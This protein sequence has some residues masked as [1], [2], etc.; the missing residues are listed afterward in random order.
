MREKAIGGGIDLWVQRLVAN[1]LTSYRVVLTKLAKY[2]ELGWEH[3][4][5]KQIL[6]NNA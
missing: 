4:V 1:L 3:Y 5:R 6:P 2:I